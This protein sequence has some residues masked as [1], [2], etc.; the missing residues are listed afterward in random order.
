[1]QNSAFQ[2]ESQDE[3]GGQ[4]QAAV[5]RIDRTAE[6]QSVK[7]FLERFRPLDLIPWT[8]DQGQG[9]IVY[10]FDP[11]RAVLSKPAITK[12]LANFKYL[13]CS[14]EIKIQVTGNQFMAGKLYAVWT[15]PNRIGS[16]VQGN[17]LT[18]ISGVREKV[19]LYPTSSDAVT[20]KI[21]LMQY[22]QYFDLQKYGGDH[23]YDQSMVMPELDNYMTLGLVTVYVVAPLVATEPTGVA[24]LAFYARLVDVDLP[25]VFTEETMNVGLGGYSGF[26]A[27]SRLMDTTNQPLLAAM[28]QLD[29]ETSDNG[30][31]VDAQL[32]G[33]GDFF[34]S[35]KQPEERITKYKTFNLTTGD[36]R[37]VLLSM[38]ANNSVTPT[39][40]NQL[41]TTTS[42]ADIV[43]IP[44]ILYTAQLTSSIPRRSR[45]FKWNPS[46]MNT[47][48][49]Y[50][51]PMP[52]GYWDGV[53]TTFDKFSRMALSTNPYMTKIASMFKY[54]RG[55]M[56]LD[57]EFV[58]T[59]FTRAMFAVNWTPGDT[60]L[61]GDFSS[62]GESSDPNAWP[63]NYTQYIVVAGNTKTRIEIPFYSRY[64]ALSTQ[65]NYFQAHN[66][67]GYR[68]PLH[69]GSLEISVVNPVTTTT[70]DQ[71]PD[72]MMIVS[73]SMK[74]AEFFRPTSEQLSN[75]QGEAY[76][77]TQS[78][79][80][81]AEQQGL[82]S[83]KKKDSVVT[84]FGKTMP[85]DTK[86]MFGESIQDIMQLTKRDT[87]MSYWVKPK[88]GAGTAIS[89]FSPEMFTINTLPAIVYP[90]T[91]PALGTVIGDRSFAT[92]LSTMFLQARGE[93]T[94]TAMCKSP[95]ALSNVTLSKNKNTTY[96]E[97]PGLLETMT[98][99][100]VYT[101]S[102]AGIYFDTDTA[103]IPASVSVPYYTASPFILTPDVGHTKMGVPTGATMPADILTN[104]YQNVTGIPGAYVNLEGEANQQVD[105]Y[106]H[107]NDGFTFSGLYPDK[108]TMFH[109][110]KYLDP[111]VGIR[112]KSS[113]T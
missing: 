108:S 95:V 40:P 56:V 105:F 67:M 86:Q 50:I 20:L 35:K 83:S 12:K 54:W 106:V 64:W 103:V 36:D 78:S 75:T 48:C 90:D 14:A 102:G 21:P 101:Q 65:L 80:V 18:R 9:S 57:L 110:S 84:E 53:A 43:S 89:V 77:L 42:I 13:N 91:P 58:C 16:T 11:L 96:L 82:F 62:S 70:I 112:P 85:I 2:Q 111:L 29:A 23:Y 37:S 88:H 3:V 66:N 74:D 61:Y 24:E 94:Y 97:N 32:Q 27:A 69:N 5:D 39:G 44:Q 46:P 10:S 92:F 107:L 99:K 73:A 6:T 8:Q 87:Y 104:K 72:I 79:V 38:D 17:T 7:Q 93:A 59:S 41:P 15:P 26:S 60:P 71:T 51:R 52:T 28:A 81:Q 47:A 22:N 76:L 55:T 63:E 19:E 33:F 113:T 30:R 45:I 4:V 109:F 100:Q 49:E 31:T 25:P 1:V 68:L 34:R 98:S